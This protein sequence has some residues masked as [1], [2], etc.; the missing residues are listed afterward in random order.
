MTTPCTTGWINKDNVAI[1]ADKKEWLDAF[2]FA[3]SDTLVVFD[4]RMYTET[5]NVTPEVSQVMLTMG[6]CLKLASD[7]ECA[8]QINNRTA[9]NNHVV[10]LPVRRDDGT[11]DRKL[12]LIGENRKVSEGYLPLTSANIAMVA[13]NQLGDVY[14]WGGMMSANDCSGY[15]RDVYKCF[16]LELARNTTWQANQ[17]VRKWAIGDMTNDEKSELIKRLPV[18]AVLIF[19]GHEMLYL[20]SEGDKLY[21][22]SSV[23]NLVLDGANTRVRGGIIN[24]LDIT[25]PNGKTWLGSLHTAEIPYLPEGTVKD[26]NSPD[27]RIEEIPALTY[28]GMEQEPAVTVHD[29]AGT[30]IPGAEYTVRFTDNKNAG[31]AHV[32]ITGAGDYSGTLTTDF[33]IRKAANTLSAKGRTVSASYSKL[34]SGNQSIAKKAAIT[35]KS[36]KGK[37]TYSK[38]SGPKMISVAGKTGKI[39]LMK[40]LPKGKCRLKVKVTAAGNGNYKKKSVTATVTIKVK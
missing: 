5:S 33:T 6:T 39:T 21:V 7:E 34:I 19:G 36:A 17:P 4:D 38:L 15:V 9:H 2:N 23:S 32:Q 35:V 26:M 24:T 3:P 40:G 20:G 16:G 30:L 31:T 18:G 29:N 14:G 13:M 11:Y 37:V 28:N 12:C 22:I 27:I 8:G 10:W 1:C 25:R